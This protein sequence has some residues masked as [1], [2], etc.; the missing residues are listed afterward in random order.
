LIKIAKVVGCKV[1]DEL[2]NR[3]SELGIISDVLRSSLDFYLKHYHNKEVNHTEN[4]VNQSCFN[5]KYQNL[6]ELIDK[7]FEGV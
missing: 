6:C 3:I 4:T 2:Y 1:T 7:H 5:C